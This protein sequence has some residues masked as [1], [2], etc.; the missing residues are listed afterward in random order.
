MKYTKEH[1]WIDIDGGSAKIG[2]TE[3]AQKSLGEIVFVEL[4]EVGA[5]VEAGDILG[6]VESVKTV[7]DIYSPV[8][9]EVTK[10][11]TELEENPG[12]INEAPYVNW[13]AALRLDDDV[14]SAELMDDAAYDAFCREDAENV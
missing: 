11:N 5:Q 12:R 14:I 7:S 1:E 3:Y 4:P 9:G 10:V 2:I 8:S 13:I 6:T